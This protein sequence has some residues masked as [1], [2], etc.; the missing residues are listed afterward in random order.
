MRM[1]YV[2]LHVSKSVYELRMYFVSLTYYLELSKF[3][4]YS[5]LNVFWEV[6]TVCNILD[7]ATE[8]LICDDFSYCDELCSSWLC[9]AVTYATVVD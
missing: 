5:K 2:E 9:A 6:V 7:M 4:I 8:N 3:V 1:Y